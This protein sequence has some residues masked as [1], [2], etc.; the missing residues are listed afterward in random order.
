MNRLTR[1]DRILCGVYAGAAL[2]ALVLTQIA[3]VRHINGYDGNWLNGFLKDSVV[4]PAAAFGVIDLLS[5]ALVALVFV[6]VEGR[7]LGMR[8]LWVYV[9]VACVIAISVAF[10][11]F[12]VMRQVKLAEAREP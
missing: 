8:R 7:R 10:P 11:A 2:I 1:T 9:V 3:L 5:V 6:V 4:N 12:L